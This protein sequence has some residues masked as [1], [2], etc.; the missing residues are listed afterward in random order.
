MSGWPGPFT[1]KG[2]VG[3]V[4]AIN[5]HGGS[6]EQVVGARASTGMAGR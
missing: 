3:A 5:G 2:K 1:P 4:L 6:G